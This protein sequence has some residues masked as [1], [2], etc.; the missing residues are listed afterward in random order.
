MSCKEGEIEKKQTNV[1]GIVSVCVL[2]VLLLSF[3]ITVVVLKIKKNNQVPGTTGGSS[4]EII[5]RFEGFFMGS[6]GQFS[7]GLVI[8]I[9]L[10]GLV[11]AFNMLIMTPLVQVSIPD[12]EIFRRGISL[13]RNT[14]IYPGQFVLSVFSFFVSLFIIFIIIELIFQ[15]TKLLGSKV[16]Y[17]LFVVVFSLILIGLLIWNIYVFATKPKI[18]CEKIQVGA[19]NVENKMN[20]APPVNIGSIY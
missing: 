7:I 16:L 14:Y 12:Q 2:G 10:A 6:M 9:M 13:G 4:F 17:W 18:V 5:N 19:L 3:I 1:P 15:I 8:A 20:F 11:S